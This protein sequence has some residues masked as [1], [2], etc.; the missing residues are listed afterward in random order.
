MTRLSWLIAAVWLLLGV[1][2]RAQAPL[3]AV[4]DYP[5]AEISAV[6]RFEV[7][8]DGAPNYTSVGV[9]TPEVLPT[10]PPGQHSYGWVLPALNNGTHT[11]L[12]RACDANECSF[13]ATVVFR[14]L[15]PPQN[16]RIVR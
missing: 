2:L 5:D 13:D 16:P 14:Q 11:L 4:W 7:R 6:V 9:P 15:G 12:V 8:L 10:T 1:P 3:R